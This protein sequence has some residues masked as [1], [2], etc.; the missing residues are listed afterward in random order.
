MEVIYLNAK[1]YSRGMIIGALIGTAFLF[2]DKEAR[3][4]I[5]E[6]TNKTSSKLRGY[7]QK[8]SYLIHD[9]TVAYDSCSNCMKSITDSL[10]D[11]VSKV[12]QVMD[13][14]EDR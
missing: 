1:K 8:P 3:K 9:V 5:K 14:L 12:E 10:I 4:N 13:K 6:V 2:A 7:V 11:S